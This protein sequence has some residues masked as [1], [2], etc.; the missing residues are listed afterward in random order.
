M[1]DTYSLE[2]LFTLAFP[3]LDA[4]GQQ[5]AKTLYQ[6][7][8]S[9]K[10][11]S[12]EDFS[13]KINLPASETEQLLNSWTGVIFD[14]KNNI[15]A[16]WGLSTT[17]TTHRFFINDIELFTWCAWDLLFMPH[18]LQQ[19]V[20]TET[21]CPITDTSIQLTISEQCI[22]QVSPPEAMI[23][24]IKPDLDA[25]KQNVTGSFCQYIFF[26][27]SEAA[28]KQWQQQQEN[29]FLLSMDQGYRLGE[30]IIKKVFND[31]Q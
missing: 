19:T 8:A 9:G 2:Q 20:K 17:P 13:K 7:L 3:Q 11:I 14:D 31:I 22:E 12:I 23:T 10:A 26:V 16:F 21:R 1:V 27:A 6:S 28:G 29:G 5:Q 30:N 24:F 4:T 25:L 15:T 18:I